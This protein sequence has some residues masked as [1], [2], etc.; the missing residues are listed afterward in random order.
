MIYTDLCD[1]R[2]SQARFS[3]PGED[4]RS[5]VACTFPKPISK[6]QQRQAGKRSPNP[7]IQ[8]RIAQ[9]LSQNHRGHNNQLIGKGAIQQVCIVTGLSLQECDPGARVGGDHRSV[10]SSAALR[11]NRIFPRSAR[12]RA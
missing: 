7:G 8:L 9:K 3:P 4:H 1:Q 10:F 5:Q 12:S 2:V 6:L 11:E